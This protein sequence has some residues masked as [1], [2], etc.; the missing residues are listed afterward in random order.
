[1]FKRL[2]IRDPNKKTKIKLFLWKSDRWKKGRIK[3]LNKLKTVFSYLAK[4]ERFTIQ[5]V[6]LTSG[7]LAIQF[8][9][10]D[11]R[12]G[13]VIL[14][15]FGSYFLTWWS[16][17][18]DIEGI[19]WFLLFILPVFFTASLS[20]FYFLLPQRMITRVT[21]TAF[22]AIATYAIL[23]IENIY[24]VAVQRSIQLLRAAQSVGLLLTLTVIFLSSNIIYSLSLPYFLN[25]ILISL[26]SF[27]LALQSLWS[28]NLNKQ[29]NKDLIFYAFIVG[30]GAG[31]LALAL[32]FW[33]IENA[34]FSLLL[35]ATFY[36]LVGVIQQYLGGRL[37]MNVIREY[38]IVFLF[39][40]ILAFITTKWG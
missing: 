12:F 26:I 8:I 5:T 19:E 37:F 4:R 40:Y 31:E 14:L 7:L 1:M 18:E 11:V 34:T 29:L 23:L 3:H 21:T 10:Q 39:T 25:L 38:I 28:I 20:L 17:K 33:P 9:W 30:L 6:I 22:F 32:S 2:V 24:N 16:L 35:S 15:V 13:L 36:I 27:F